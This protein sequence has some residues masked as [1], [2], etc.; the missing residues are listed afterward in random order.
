M[1]PVAPSPICIRSFKIYKFVIYKSASGR[2]YN[3]RR[4][5][6][7]TRHD[8]LVISFENNT[9]PCD[10]RDPYEQIASD[11]DRKTVTLHGNYS[12]IDHILPVERHLGSWLSHE[13]TGEQR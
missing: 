13:S 7:D 2:T 10:Q 8:P 12:R 1:V 3:V 6:V 9:Q 4:T 11:Q 5:D